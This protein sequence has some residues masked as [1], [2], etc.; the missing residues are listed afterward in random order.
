M[1]I[2][3]FSARKTPQTRKPEALNVLDGNKGLGDKGFVKGKL[4]KKFS[5]K[6]FQ[7]V[8]C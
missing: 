3:L 8:S 1:I 2:N 4:L 7:N 6:P 5:L